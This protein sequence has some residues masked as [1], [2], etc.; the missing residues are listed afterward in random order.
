[1]GGGMLRR[2]GNRLGWMDVVVVVTFAF[3]LVDGR[4]TVTDSDLIILFLKK[5]VSRMKNLISSKER[6]RPE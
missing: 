2:D 5:T 1:M 6:F 4:W 3:A